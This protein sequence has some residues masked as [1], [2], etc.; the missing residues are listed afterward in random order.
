MRTQ[1]G[2][3]A[4][5]TPVDDEPRARAMEPAG[6]RVEALFDQNLFRIHVNRERSSAFW[7][8][9]SGASAVWSSAPAS[10]LT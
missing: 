10:A 4:R 2:R 8:R 7:M 3:G 6:G 9:R 1:G 5:L